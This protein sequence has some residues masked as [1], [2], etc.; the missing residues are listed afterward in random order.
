MRATGRLTSSARQGPDFLLIGTKRGGTT[1]M[2][3][4]LLQHPCVIPLYP[5]PRQAPMR[6]PIKGTRYFTH[7]ADR[8]EAWYRGFFPTVITRRF[9][10][11]RRGGAVVSGESTPYYLFHPTVAQRAHKV[12]PNA[13]IIAV[14]RHPVERAYSHW[15][16]RRREGAEQL[17]FREA[18]EAEAERLNGEQARIIDDP[19]YVSYA[20]EHCSY[21]AQSRYADSLERWMS[22]Y[23]SSQIL[24]LRSEDFYCD[25]QAA[26]ACVSDHL[27]IPRHHF[28]AG[29]QWNATTTSPI[30][31]ADRAFVLDLVADDMARVATLTGGVV[32]W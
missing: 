2:Y 19:T 26:M 18:V 20:H 5:S 8:S 31:A 7:H 30:D 11:A 32:S 4:Y 22:S 21:V 15:A 16:E 6:M 27:Q 14:L 24:I 10:A 29:R 9:Y 25:V 1:S 13:K 23:P 17:T 3:R 28:D 12:A